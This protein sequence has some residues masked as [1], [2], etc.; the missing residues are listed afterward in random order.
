MH[1]LKVHKMYCNNLPPLQY[2]KL[3]VNV[4]KMLQKHFILYPIEQ[5]NF[6]N[7]AKSKFL[8]LLTL[9]LT[10]TCNLSLYR[11]VCKK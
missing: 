7:Y 6:P 11:C 1:V 4:S 2:A 9:V 10:L 3:C 5:N 8:F